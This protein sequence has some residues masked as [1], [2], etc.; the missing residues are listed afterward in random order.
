M[1]NP[2][3]SEL[4][5]AAALLAELREAGLLLTSSRPVLAAPSAASP[6]RI[7]PPPPATKAPGPVAPRAASPPPPPVAAPATPRQ[8]VYRAERVR[9][10]LADMCKRGGFSGAVLADRSGLA[11]AEFNS[12]LDVDPVAAF[13]SV[14]GGTLEQAEKL[15]GKRDANNLA[16]D[17]NYVEKI[18]VRK[19]SLAQ[20]PAFLLLVCPQSIDERSEVELSIDLIAAVLAEE[21]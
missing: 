1:T 16:L 7:E 9:Q 12:P 11:L 14:V 3:S 4:G 5:R 19:F 6:P 15:L 13:A 20:Q 8:P 18:V 2:A 10:L 17:I 21:T